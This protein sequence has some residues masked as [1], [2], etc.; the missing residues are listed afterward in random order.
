MPDQT[1]K[2][3]FPVNRSRDVVKKK[4]QTGTGKAENPQKK[5]QQP[6]SEKKGIIDTFA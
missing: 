4:K 3:V 6:N 2:P 1:I 5:D